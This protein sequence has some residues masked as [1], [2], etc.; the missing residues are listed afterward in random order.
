MAWALRKT[1][2]HDECAVHVYFFIPTLCSK[3]KPEGA[4]LTVIPLS[5]PEP[6]EP[7][8]PLESG[9]WSM[10]ASEKCGESI[11]IPLQPLFSFGLCCHYVAQVGL[12]LLGLIL[13]SRIIGMS[14]PESPYAA[15][16][17]LF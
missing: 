1:L 14:Q 11:L 10:H 9:K 7:W 16:F 13:V 15:V 17:V 3:I 4:V 5:H 12:E 6:P 8:V 2:S